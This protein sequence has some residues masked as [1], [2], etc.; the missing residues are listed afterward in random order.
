MN[1]KYPISVLHNPIDLHSVTGSKP[2]SAY[3]HTILYASRLAIDKGIELLMQVA[4]SRPDIRFLI[5][6]TGDYEPLVNRYAQSHPN[7]IVLGNLNRTEL[8]RTFDKA[9]FLIL[10]SIWYENNPNII[11]EA[12]A[13][14]LP[15]IGSRIGGIPELIGE[16]RGYLF[17]ANQPG[18]LREL[19]DQLYSQP[20]SLHE[21]TAASARSFISQFSTE[22]YYERFIELLRSKQLLRDAELQPE[23]K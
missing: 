1:F 20:E 2:G 7:I 12:M 8:F 19:I 4:A 10:P 23:M 22:S 15:V 21:Q 13:Y 18:S 6:G 14:G 5:A 11:I 9:D 16:G 17:E 3:Q